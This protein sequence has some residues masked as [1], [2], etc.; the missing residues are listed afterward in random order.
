VFGSAAVGGTRANAITYISPSFGGFTLRAQ[1]GSGSAGREV[2]EASAANPAS[3]LSVDKNIRMSLMA[4]YEAGPLSAAV[5]H[6]RNEVTQSARAAGF[7]AT[8]GYGATLPATTTAITNTA[9]RTGKMTQLGASYDFGVAK[10]GLVYMDGESGG[11]ATS[12]ANT[13]YKATQLSAAFPIGAFAPFVSVAG[14]RRPT[15]RQVL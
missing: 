9:E 1:Y 7:V 13:E 3:G 2:Y 6:T 10:V 11:S 4:K 14:P 12:T 5:A 8:G 15:R